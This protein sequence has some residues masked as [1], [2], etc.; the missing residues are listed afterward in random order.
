MLQNP[1]SRKIRK[2]AQVSAQ[3]GP[4]LGINNTAGRGNDNMCS[5]FSCRTQS[6][7]HLRVVNENRGNDDEIVRTEVAVDAHN[8]SGDSRSQ[9]L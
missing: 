3:N 7:S 9:R 2:R 1:H 5:A 8:I 6:L 4:K